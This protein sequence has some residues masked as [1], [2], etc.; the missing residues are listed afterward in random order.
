[1]QIADPAQGY[2]LIPVIWYEAPKGAKTYTG[3]SAFSSGVWDR[4]GELVTYELGDQPPYNLPYYGGTNVWGYCGQEVV[5]TPEQF[6]FGLSAADLA[7][8]P[9]ALPHCCVKAQRLVAGVNLLPKVS[10]HP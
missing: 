5:G 3:I 4:D 10:S 1:M 8:P 7:S 6:Q 9:P 2:K